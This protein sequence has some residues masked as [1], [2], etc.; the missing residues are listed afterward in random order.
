MGEC[1]DCQWWCRDE[2]ADDYDEACPAAWCVCQLGSNPPW[3]AAPPD[4]PAGSGPY[5][6]FGA[7]SGAIIVT[8]PDFGCNQ[9]APR[10]EA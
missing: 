5:G 1:Q 3:D 4:G 9:F 10:E 2:A 6:Q 8:A 7:T